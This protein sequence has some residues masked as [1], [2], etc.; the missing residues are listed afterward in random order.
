[1]VCFSLI[2]GGNRHDGAPRTATPLRGFAG[3]LD[4]IAEGKLAESRKLKR[5]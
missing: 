4:A 1:M 5:L 3:K 2:G